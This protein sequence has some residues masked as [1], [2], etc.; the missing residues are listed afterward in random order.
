MSTLTPLEQENADLRAK[1]AAA[2]R[3]VATAYPTTAD[4]LTAVIRRLSE[5]THVAAE[6]VTVWSGYDDDERGFPE[7]TTR[8]AAQQYAEHR[9]REDWINWGNAPDEIIEIGWSE[10]KAYTDAHDGRAGMSDLTVDDGSTG[11]VVCQRTVHPTAAAALLAETAE[12]APLGSRVRVHRPGFPFDGMAGTVAVLH[13]YGE[14]G[15][16]GVAVDGRDGVM[17]FSV[18][19]VTVLPR[20]AVAR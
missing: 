18:D 12:K 16:V 20:E 4:E 3:C 19:D 7:F 10:R 11:Y 15:K 2:V 5:I 1:L 13:P 14:V 6:T 9:Y 17:V 8:H